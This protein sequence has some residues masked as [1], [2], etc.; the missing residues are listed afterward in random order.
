MKTLN[1]A[2]ISA[3]ALIGISTSA[4]AAFFV[5]GDMQ[6][7]QPAAGGNEMTDVDGDNIF[8]ITFTD[9]TATDVHGY[10]VLNGA[11]WDNQITTAN[12]HAEVAADGTLTIY[13]DSNIVNEEVDTKFVAG[14]DNG[15]TTFTAV[16][17]PTSVPPAAPNTAPAALPDSWT[18]AGGFQGWNNNNPET[19]MTNIGGDIWELEFAVAEA[20]DHGWK[21]VKTDSDW[22]T[23]IGDI[24]HKTPDQEPGNINFTTTEADQIVTFRI[25]AANGLFATVIPEPASLALLGL[26]GLMLLRRR[27]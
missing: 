14:W 9:L 23:Q 24:G 27:K 7:W 10:K 15:Y 17:S 20:G 3:A 12:Q 25:D 16:S 22:S 21:A 26:G 18:V 2:A 6:G 8:E 13:Y 4:N 19:A 5:A 1:L 11:S